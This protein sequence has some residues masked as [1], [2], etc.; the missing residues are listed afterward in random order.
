MIFVS[1][2]LGKIIKRSGASHSIQL[3]DFYEEIEVL[4]F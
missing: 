3:H 1:F 2:P 4:S